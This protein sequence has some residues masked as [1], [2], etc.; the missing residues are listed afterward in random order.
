MGKFGYSH[1]TH[2]KK[3]NGMSLKRKIFAIFSFALLVSS[4]VIIIVL[5]S[6]DS[7]TLRRIVAIASA[8]ILLLAGVLITFAVIKKRGKDGTD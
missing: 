5:V 3:K 8:S 6:V 1:G 2:N 4:I 7:E